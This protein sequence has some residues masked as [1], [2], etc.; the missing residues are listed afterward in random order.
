MTIKGGGATFPLLRRT[1]EPGRATPQNRSREPAETAE[2][3]ASLP[4]EKGGASGKSRAA[5]ESSRARRSSGG[6]RNRCSASSHPGLERFVVVQRI[7]SGVFP[8]VAR[9]RA[10][11]VGNA[12]SGG[13]RKVVRPPRAPA[14]RPAS[15]HPGLWMSPAVL[16]VQ[17]ARAPNRTQRAPDVSRIWTRGA[18]AL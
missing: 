17:D 14:S 4:P 5:G 3:D 10:C 1:A 6:T 8:A 18:S 11:P 16:P 15:S 2:D 9:R 7:P 12:R 13:R